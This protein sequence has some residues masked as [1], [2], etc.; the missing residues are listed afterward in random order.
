[1]RRGAAKARRRFFW[2]RV[3]SALPMT[4]M[5]FDTADCINLPETSSHEFITGRVHGRDFKVGSYLRGGGEHARW[6]SAVLTPVDGLPDDV[7]VSVDRLG[8]V[9]R[10]RDLHERVE[11]S[12]AEDK[13]ISAPASTAEM[14][15]LE[16]IVG[17]D[18]PSFIEQLTEEVLC[19]LHGGIRVIDGRQWLGSTGDDPYPSARTLKRAIA[20][21]AGDLEDVGIAVARMVDHVQMVMDDAAAIDRQ[22][23]ESQPPIPPPRSRTKKRR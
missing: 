14:G 16:L 8:A 21:N 6:R 4:R 15:G 3:A 18:L 17:T 19:S 13:I 11:C 9:A 10:G 1:M 12:A 22:F 20:G 5:R 23:S 7:E 2:E